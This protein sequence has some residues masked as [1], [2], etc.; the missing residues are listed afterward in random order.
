MY[1]EPN[2]STRSRALITHH[3]LTGHKGTGVC[4]LPDS[5]KV[6]FQAT[7]LE[8][9]GQLP[10]QMQRERNTLKRKFRAGEM[11]QRLNALTDF[12]RS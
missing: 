1:L 4:Y 5:T 12:R 3:D 9:T 7:E 11:A 2:C 10:M 8:A 6:P